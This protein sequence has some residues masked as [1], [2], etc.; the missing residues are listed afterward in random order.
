VRFSVC[1]LVTT[2]SV[3]LHRHGVVFVSG[4]L[5]VSVHSDLPY[6]SASLHSCMAVS[7]R[8][9]EPDRRALDQLWIFGSSSCS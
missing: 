5:L 6:L 1:L 3:C 9:R 4:L 7:A 2:V 8:E